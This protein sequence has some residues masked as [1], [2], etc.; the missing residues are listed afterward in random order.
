MLRIEQINEITLAFHIYDRWKV[1]EIQ[2][3]RKTF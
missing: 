1:V 2:E 3:R